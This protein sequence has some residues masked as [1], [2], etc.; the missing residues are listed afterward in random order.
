MFFFQTQQESSKLKVRHNYQ[1]ARPAYV[2]CSQCHSRN[3]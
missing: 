3:V 1:I 2:Q